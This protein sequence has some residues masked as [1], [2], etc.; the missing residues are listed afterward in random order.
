MRVRG[1]PNVNEIQYFAAGVINL[2]STGIRPVSGDIWLDELRVT[3][4]RRDVGTAA[5]FSANGNIADLGT[6]N[7]SYQTRD[8]Y[9]RGLSTSTRGGS[10]QNL[11][12]GATDTRL[13]YSASLNLDKFMPRSWKSRIPIQFSYSKSTKTPLLRT[14]SDIVL[15][16]EIRTLERTTSES[17]TFSISPSFNR[18]GKNPLFS[19]LLNRLVNMSVSYRRSIQRSP[20]T[21]YNF[22]EGLNARYGYDFGIRAKPTLPILFFTKWVPVL[23]RLENT[24]LGLYPRS[25]RFT[26][27]FDRTLSVTDDIDNNRR[28]SFKRNMNA[29]MDMSYDILQNLS[30]SMRW[31]TRRD[32]SDDEDVNLSLSNLKL[33]LETHYGQTFS[34]KY[35]PAVF[36]F[37]TTEWSYQASYTDDWDKSSETRRSS[38]SR[39]WGVGGVFDHVRLLGG[40]AS[41]GGDRRFSGRGGG[42]RGH[43]VDVKPKGKPFYDPPLAVLRFLTNWI[44]APRYSYSTNYKASLPGMLSRPELKYRLGLT[45]ASGV[46]I[47]S[48][49][50]NESASEGQSYDLTSGFKLLGGISTDIKFRRSIS[51]DIIKRGSLYETTTT[52]WPELTIRIQRFTTFPLLKGVFNKFIDVF[53]PRT[54]YSRSTRESK[55][56]DGDFITN[57]T[58][59]ISQNPVVSVTFKLFRS[60]SLSSSYA[61]TTEKTQDYNRTTGAFQ[62]SSEM[63]RKSYGGT[64]QYS[65][66]APGGFKLPIFGRVK[67]RSQV[68]ITVDV[69]YNKSLT[70]NSDANNTLISST[71]RSDL[72]ISPEISYTFSQQIRG[73][74]SMRWT[75]TDNS[76]RV[77]HL[78]EVQVWMEIRF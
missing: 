44:S 14:G 11:G 21:P 41:G 59:S 76:G 61:L 73:G 43:Q 45:R 13:S 70:E 29:Q 46:L 31:D 35:N 54:N 8:P 62:S 18:A 32:L 9:F 1:D 63:N 53:S 5:R 50:Q 16:E 17:R 78:R 4:V 30:V 38:M 68:N 57:E 67:F 72:K 40:G 56:L 6:Y 64:A 66:S 27:N 48:T 65:F 74:L 12:S 22:T 77:N 28:S 3:D 39:S 55:D 33:G 47:S 58:E 49:S 10:D 37:F 7:F 34:T 75:D 52:G 19:L 69:K 51:R 2:D 60:L 71:E 24:A 26:G 20:R 25:W 23:N 42:R 36:S 15:P